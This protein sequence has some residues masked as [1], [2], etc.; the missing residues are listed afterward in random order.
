MS[1]VSIREKKNS[2]EFHGSVK[3]EII[4]FVQAMIAY[5]F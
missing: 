3:E 4:K 2:H 1:F 5:F